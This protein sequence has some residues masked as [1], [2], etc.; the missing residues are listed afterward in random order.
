MIKR[1]DQQLKVNKILLDSIDLEHVENKNLRQT[2]LNYHMIVTAV[3][4]IRLIQAGTPEHLKMKEDL[5]DYIEK[6]HPWEYKRLR[7]DFLGIG[8]NTPGKAGRSMDKALYKL[9][10]KVFGFN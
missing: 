9:A 5:W 8:L 3:S 6:N 4:S 10:N 1:I 2:I 7:Y